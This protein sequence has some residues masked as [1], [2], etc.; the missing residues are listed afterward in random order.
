[1][2]TLHHAAFMQGIGL[3]LTVGAGTV[4]FGWTQYDD[5][6]SFLPKHERDKLDG[7]AELMVAALHNLFPPIEK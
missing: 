6:V 5:N 1:M 3:P 7:M 2:L 4:I